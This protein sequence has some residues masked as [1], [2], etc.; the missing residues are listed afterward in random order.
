MKKTLLVGLDA[1]CWDYVN[2]LLTAGRLP[3]LQG[4]I[5]RGVKGTLE[6]TLPATTPTAWGSII[7]GKNPG[8]HGVYSHLHRAP[9]SYDFF[10]TNSHL[11]QGTP[12]WKRL[13]E[14][15]V[16]VGLV[17]VPYTHPPD[18]IDSFV[19]GG[20]G[21]PHSVPDITHPQTVLDWIEQHYGTYE[22]TVDMGKLSTATPQAIFDQDRKHQSGL[23]QI[24]A[25]L[26]EEYQIDVLT[27]NLMLLDHSNHKMPQM[28]MVEEA[29]IESDKDLKYLISSFQPENIMLIS[30]HGSRR[31]KGEFL[32]Y[33]WLQD[34]GYYTR[35]LL[36]HR[37]Q[38]DV[39]NWILV[40]KRQ[41]NDGQ[42]M[43]ADKIFRKIIREIYTRLTPPLKNYFWKYINPEFPDSR[44]LI[45]F[46]EKTDYQRSI[47]FPESAYA[48]LLYLNI[49]GREPQGVLPQ[50]GAQG[51]LAEMIEKLTA[52]KDPYYSEVI[53][54]HV[55]SKEM[56]YTGQAIGSAP[57]L[58]LDNYD[59]PW[60]VRATSGGSRLVKTDHKYFLNDVDEYGL[61]SRNGIF[62]FSGVDFISGTEQQ[63]YS[64]MDIPAT[65]LYLYDVPIPEDLD[66]IV[67]SSVLKPE[68]I[69]AQPI[70]KQPGDS[71]TPVTTAH[72]YS[73]EETEGLYERLRALGYMD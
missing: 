15:G 73:P 11:R 59:T 46:S 56:I 20:F 25:G 57:D 17:N 18:Q 51:L 60:V 37:E 2:P 29:I 48:G 41:S 34:Q 21:T 50:T 32:L 69:S 31:V 49:L 52:I 28:D 19:V 71:V 64:V 7:T 13:N 65:L 44:D 10:P 23:I 40:N 42:A 38:K 54:N 39:L 9:G 30:D 6:S 4:L 22:P 72:I 47:V 8:K 14:Q 24:A 67:M 70:R 16:K 63:T 35:R 12:F 3:T 5:D 62:I 26:A 53:F 58:I 33:Q 36:N 45:E 27:I 55:Y 43:F 1:A 61:H 66:G 68:V